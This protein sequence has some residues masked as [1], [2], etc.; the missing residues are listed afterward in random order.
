MQAF[1]MYQKRNNG[2]LRLFPFF[3]LSATFL[4]CVLLALPAEG[5][6]KEIGKACIGDRNAFDWDTNAQCN[7][8]NLIK[9][10]I[11]L[12]PVTKPPY[13]STACDASKAGMLQWTGTSVQG[14]DGTQ[15]ISFN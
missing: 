3:R 2:H 14:C 1:Q 6:E 4:F 5:A 12:G 8:T 10:P 11:L 13:T 15:W 7:G 9:G